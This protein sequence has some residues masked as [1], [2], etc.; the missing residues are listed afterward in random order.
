[1]PIIYIFKEFVFFFIISI[2]I[3]SEFPYFKFSLKRLPPKSIVNFICTLQVQFLTHLQ[4]KKSLKKI[5]QKCII[6]KGLAFKPLYRNVLFFDSVFLVEKT[7]PFL[8]SR[9]M[10]EKVRRLPMKLQSFKKH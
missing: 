2:F 5:F 9:R 6:F 10:T 7:R 1:M 8:R 3:K 4:K